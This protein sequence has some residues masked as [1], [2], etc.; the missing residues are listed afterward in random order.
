MRKNFWFNFVYLVKPIVR[1]RHK[2]DQAISADFG[3][4]VTFKCEVRTKFCLLQRSL[5][6]PPPV[7]SISWADSLLGTRRRCGHRQWFFK[8]SNLLSNSRHVS[9]DSPQCSE[10]LE[11]LSSYIFNSSL[12]IHHVNQNDYGEY[13]CVSKNNIG[14]ERIPFRLGTKGQYVRPILDGDKPLVSGETPA[15]LSYEEVCPPQSDCPFCPAPK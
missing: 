15:V 10:C 3:A 9:S 12:T 6:I 13:H 1:I 4:T 7:W 14:L 8:V 5:T 11:L 2:W